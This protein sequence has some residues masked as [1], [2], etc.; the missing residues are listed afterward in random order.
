MQFSSITR[1]GLKIL[2]LILMNPVMIPAHGGAN[3][4]LLHAGALD[5]FLPVQHYY[6]FISAPVNSPPQRPSQPAGPA[7]VLPGIACSYSA[8]ASD[9]DGDRLVYS[10]DWGDGGNSSVGPC[11]SGA[12]ASIEHTW[13]RSGSYQVSA[14]ASDI[15]NAV[16]SESSL[17]AFWQVVC[18]AWRD[19]LVLHLGRGPG[20]RSADLQLRLGRRRQ[21]ERGAM[22]LWGY[23]QHRAYLE[24]IGLLS[25]ESQGNR[26]RK[27]CV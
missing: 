14:R 6:P 4:P 11:D 13:S 12:M 23:G 9:P 22:R 1:I 19:L 27:C 15:A 17:D 5:C 24:Q 26:H 25:G 21:F 10:F 3:E 2:I 18:P 7:L 8:F 16:A 20:W